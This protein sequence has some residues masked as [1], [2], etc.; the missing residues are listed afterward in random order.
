MPDGSAK[1][2]TEKIRVKRYGPWK[3][4]NEWPGECGPGEFEDAWNV[5]FDG[6]VIRPVGGSIPYAPQSLFFELLLR[7]AYVFKFGVGAIATL[8][9]DMTKKVT[10]RASPTASLAGFRTNAT[11]RIYL[12]FTHPVSLIYW[13]I[14]FPNANAS[15]TTLKYYS[16]ATGWT[17]VAGFTDNTALAGATLGKTSTTLPFSMTWT[18]PTDWVP[19]QIPDQGAGGA[20]PGINTR[21]RLYWIEMSVSAMFSAPVDIY[22]VWTG[23]PEMAQGTGWPPINGLYQWRR[24]TGERLLYVGMDAKDTGHARLYV[25]DRTSQQAYPVVVTGEHLRSGPDARWNF[26]STGKGIVACNGYTL[27]YGTPDNPFAMRTFDAVAL[28]EASGRGNQPPASARFITITADNRLGIVD[29][30]NGNAFRYSDPFGATWDIKSSGEVP[31]GGWHVWD[32]TNIDLAM[33]KFGG[34]ITAVASVGYKTLLFTAATTH[35]WTEPTGAVLV[36]GNVGCV[37]PWSVAEAGDSVFFLAQTG[38]YR[39]A[40][41]SNEKISRRVEPTL[42]SMDML[43]A[44]RSTACIYRKK[45]QY[46]IAI[47]ALG[48]TGVPDLVLVYDYV[49]DTWSKIGKPPLSIFGYSANHVMLVSIG[50]DETGE[51]LLTVFWNLPGT[52]LIHIILQEDIGVVRVSGATSLKCNQPVVVFDRMKFE[53]QQPHTIREVWFVHRTTGGN[54]LADAGTGPLGLS[55]RVLRDGQTWRKIDGTTNIYAGGDAGGAISMLDPSV[56]D[57]NYTRQLYGSGANSGARNGTDPWRVRRFVSS[58]FSAGLTG[59]DF[60]IMVHSSGVDTLTAMIP[61]FAIRGF[62]VQLIP[63]KSF[64]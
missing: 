28:K 44:R 61:D 57:A 52:D 8:R 63:R 42:R 27:L 33:D 9:E 54:V 20:P 43:S 14:G 50:D 15:V 23:A 26:I 64:R 1:T 25:Y 18:L 45:N 2:S 30:S 62:E 17:T 35:V 56:A 13:W 29:G 40:N 5:E 47:P 38:I 21:L 6:D 34:P 59:R 19:T 53:D 41:G 24:P 11:D 31:L 12:G 4:I 58:K 37:A 7:P 16:A 22:N 46:R 10:G 39:H 60:Q 3:G 49:R 51:E 48:H 36:D 55:I 32:P